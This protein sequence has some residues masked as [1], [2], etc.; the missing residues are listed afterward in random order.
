MTHAK[1]IGVMNRADAQ[2]LWVDIVGTF[3]K[4]ILLFAN[5]DDVLIDY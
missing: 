2:F 1:T 3:W 5:V 4:P